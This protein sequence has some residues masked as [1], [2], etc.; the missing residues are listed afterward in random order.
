[1]ELDAELEAG[2][3]G[4][5]TRRIDWASASP[6]DV[7]AIRMA[8][9]DAVPT[10]MTEPP[11]IV[12]DSVARLEPS[13]SSVPVRI[14]RPRD[15]SAIGPGMVWLHGGGYILGSASAP[16]ARVT[17]WTEALGCTIVSVDYRLAP[18]HPFPAPLDDCWLALRWAV[19]NAEELGI[20]RSRL[21]VGGGSAGAGLAAACALLA[22]DTGQAIPAFQLLQYP[23]LD[24]RTVLKDTY[25]DLVWPRAANHLGWTCYLG[26][27]AGTDDAPAYAAPG[28]VV[29]LAGLP[30]TGVFVG[31]MDLFRDED[32][33]Y[34]SR[35]LAADVSVEL[36]VYAGAPHG[37]DNVTSAAVSRRCRRDMEDFLRGVMAV[38]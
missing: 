17:Q 35:L 5:P 34:A 13:G 12:E 10:S 32:V 29:D 25:D 38:Q 27:N 14:F 3:R 37:F 21:G 16:D 24:D 33:A 4:F 2:L 15:H 22:R 28:R 18:E 1:V 20:D 6:D 36:H 30:P 9:A 11:A 7:G 19:A 26:R 23:M 31:A 8:I